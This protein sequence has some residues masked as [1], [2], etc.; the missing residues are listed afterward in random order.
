MNGIDAHPAHADPHSTQPFH[1][2]STHQ[3]APSINGVLQSHPV[4]EEEEPY[5]IKCVCGYHD[6]DG[7]TVLCEN[8]NSWQHIECYYP[9]K[10]VPEIHKCVDC[11]PRHLDA[12]RAA[13][14]QKRLR[15]AQAGGDKKTKRPASKNLKKKS[16][17]DAAQLN[18][19]HNGFSGHGEGTSAAA[20]DRRIGSPRDQPPP[21]KRP[22][23]NHKV[24]GSSMLLNE[25]GNDI[26][27]SAPGFSTPYATSPVKASEIPATNGDGYLGPLFSQEFIGLYPSCLNYQSIESNSFHDIG[28]TSNL[29]TWLK[30]PGALA[31]VAN[32]KTRAEVFQQYDR[33]IEDL[34]APGIERHVVKDD[35][36]SR[37]GGHPTWQWLSIDR[38]VVEGAFVGELIGQIGR[39]ED[40]M[41]EPANR[42]SFLRHPEPFVFF[43]PHLPIYI[44]TRVEGNVLRG[45]RRSCRPNVKMNILI[46]DGM[47]YHFCFIAMKNIAQDEEI[48]IGWDLDE[49]VQRLLYASL[50]SGNIKKE[51]FLLEEEQYISSWVTGVLSNFGGCPCDRLLGGCVMDRFVRSN[52]VQFEP[53]SQLSNTTTKKKV[54]K[55]ARQGSPV[56]SGLVTNNLTASEAWNANDPEDEPVT[57]G[58]SVSASSQSKPGSRDL[59]PVAHPSVEGPLSASGL[60]M[61][62]RERRKLMQQEKL[63]EQLEHEQQS[64]KGRRKRISGGSAVNTPAATSTVCC[65]SLFLAFFVIWTTCIF[66]SNLP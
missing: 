17:K 11:A 13:E 21:A 40:Y 47:M 56:N 7:N 16:A 2:S 33:P 48:T 34:Q 58:R 37:Y 61:S 27:R 45:I 29:S 57:D 19:F 10:N 63:F 14:R 4:G 52:A 54:R 59:T 25:P 38:P 35:S 32:G 31:D 39:R 64:V 23:M 9:A 53:A 62:D 8:C 1:F 6:D 44:D 51:G 15:E 50:S 46:T 24:T 43:P 41:N 18:G 3:H 66:C 12:K 55:P 42:W 36:I 26:P 49:D 30:D 65:V 60:E 5:T 28:I 22:K 20:T